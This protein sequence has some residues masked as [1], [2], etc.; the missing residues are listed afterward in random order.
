[1]VL[2]IGID[3]VLIERI[4]KVSPRVFERVC[5][6]SEREYCDRFGEGRH[7]RY[8][9]R[10]AAK[11]AISKALGTGIAQGIGWQDLEILPTP[12]GAPLAVFHGTAQERAARMGV[13]RVLIS[14]THDTMTA[15]AIAILESDTLA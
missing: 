8:A 2:G 10:F 12:S 11:E 1:M 13:R 4:R 15:S 14:I 7:E 5:T 9:G 6:P 3:Q